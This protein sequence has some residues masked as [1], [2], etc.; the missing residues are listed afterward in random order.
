MEEGPFYPDKMRLFSDSKESA[1]NT[2]DPD[3]IPMSQDPL[4]KET[5]IHSSIVAWRITWTKKPGMLQSMGLQ[6]VRY[7]SATNTFSYL[8]NLYK[9]PE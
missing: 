9:G 4:E 3:A 8:K 2:G 6:K 5:A 1:C 7:N